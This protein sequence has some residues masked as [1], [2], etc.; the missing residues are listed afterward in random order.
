[1]K[2]NE[3]FSNVLV[4]LGLKSLLDEEFKPFSPS[5]HALTLYKLMHTASSTLAQNPSRDKILAVLDVMIFFWPINKNTQFTL[6]LSSVMEDADKLA[7]FAE[8]LQ[9][10]GFLMV[11]HRGERLDNPLYDLEAEALL[12]LARM[13]HLI[14][15]DLY[16]TSLNVLGMMQ[17]Y[18]SLLSLRQNHGITFQSF[19][20]YF[21]EKNPELMFKLFRHKITGE[22]SDSKEAIILKSNLWQR[23]TAE[24][25]SEQLEEIVSVH[26]LS[27]E[28]I[29][30]L[31]DLLEPCRFNRD[32]LVI[33]SASGI[34]ELLK[35]LSK[36]HRLNEPAV[37]PL[38]K[39]H[40][41][42]LCLTY[43]RFDEFIESHLHP[44]FYKP[45]NVQIS[46]YSFFPKGKSL[47]PTARAY[48]EN[49]FKAYDLTVDQQQ[50]LI[51]ELMSLPP[52]YANF[53]TLKN[54]QREGEILKDAGKAWLVND[55]TFYLPS[56][57]VFYLI[58]KHLSRPEC[59]PQAT[60][61]LTGKIGNEAQKKCIESGF[62]P[63]YVY[64]IYCMRRPTQAHGYKV[65]PCMYTI[66]DLYYHLPKFFVTQEYRNI[67]HQVANTFET[68]DK[69]SN[70]TLNFKGA[71]D[72]IY[73]GDL[74]LDRCSD[75]FSIRLSF[76]L[77]ELNLFSMMM[78]MMPLIASAGQ[79]EHVV[80]LHQLL[81]Q[82]DLMMKF[83]SIS[84]EK[85]GK[86]RDRFSK[87]THDPVASASNSAS[88][89]FWNRYFKEKFSRDLLE[90]P[91]NSLSRSGN[92]GLVSN[93]N[94]GP[95]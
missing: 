6:A 94:N 7:H 13:N 74:A 67:I 84:E 5:E 44:R 8:A 75:F 20:S 57:P 65:K 32:E 93:N 9:S 47:G 55:D 53:Y 33:Y 31:F 62:R 28:K 87:L 60:Q 51:L 19:Q 58:I 22:W 2:Y 18:S 12:H 72:I 59:T 46:G 71:V 29:A 3:F 76:C 30:S 68:H 27:K 85:F 23:D 25:T 92:D 64:S 17:S 14:S 83:T 49:I 35:E 24:Y 86:I 56:L 16:F 34:T 50:N 69:A 36:K 88:V 70:S 48:L 45:V 95:F 4:S 40:K 82:I 73:D 1:M 38:L 61:L 89:T 21:G 66:H 26:G 77:E 91:Q 54:L 80:R 52:Q 90:Q 43:S 63:T 11:D 79:P 81:D 37:K 15:Q 42:L 39:L 78:I 41:T 10:K